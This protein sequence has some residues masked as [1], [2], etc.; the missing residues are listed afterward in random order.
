[1]VVVREAL[2][3]IVVGI[4]RMET[5]FGPGR[6]DGW[7]AAID[8]DPDFDFDFSNVKNQRRR[9]RPS[10]LPCSNLSSRK[11]AKIAK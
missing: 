6:P 5:G 7:G 1:M 2:V 11:A 10:E 3:V 4:E 9:R 8:P